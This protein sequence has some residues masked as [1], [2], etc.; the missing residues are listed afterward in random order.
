MGY[1]VLL[2]SPSIKS[3]PIFDFFRGH[4]LSYK[5]TPQEEVLNAQLAARRRRT[6]QVASTRGAEMSEEIAWIRASFE[7]EE[8]IKDVV[9]GSTRKEPQGPKSMLDTYSGWLGEDHVDP[10]RPG[11]KEFLERLSRQ[12]RVIIFTT[13]PAE[14]VWNWLKENGMAEYVA[15]VTDRKPPAVVYIDDRAVCF[16]GDFQETLEE[17]KRFKPHKKNE[18]P[19]RGPFFAHF[20]FLLARGG[21]G[22]KYSEQRKKRTEVCL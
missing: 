10:A 12:Y 15:E 5:K 3:S 22:C 11:A 8:R 18:T 17:I 6:P 4:Y 20:K 2:L 13:Q 1:S 7:Q 21:Q 9:R 16:R 19:Q 14:K